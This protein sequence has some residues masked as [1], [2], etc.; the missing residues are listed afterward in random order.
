MSWKRPLLWLTIPLSL[1]AVAAN[2]QACRLRSPFTVN[3]QADA[4]ELTKCEQFNGDVN[5]SP[6]ASSNITL[7]GLLQVFGSLRATLPGHSDTADATTLISISSK[8]LSFVGGSLVI[9]SVSS[10]QSIALPKLKIVVGALEMSD[11]PSLV[12]L[13]LEGINSIGN[14]SLVSAPRLLEASIGADSTYKDRDIGLK[15]ITDTTDPAVVVRDVGLA[16]LSGL[17]DLYDASLIELAEL[18][19]LNNALLNTGRVGEVRIR[20]NGNLTLSTWGGPGVGT[21]EQVV[22]KLSITGVKHVSPCRSFD[23]HE[24]IAV[25][26]SVEYLH[27]SFTAVQRLEVRDN[28]RLKTLVPW[29][30]RNIWE[31]DLADV[32]IRDNPLLV[33]SQFPVRSANDTFTLLECPGSFNNSVDQWQWYPFHMETLA[34]D[35]A[36]NDTF[37]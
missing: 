32:L 29:N 1:F 2:A 25:N 12:D 10:L 6:S 16:S 8:T 36:I 17:V 21:T 26:N 5:I 14:F 13:H 33:L 23:V 11:L 15:Y 4:D 22:G 24:F 7:D 19:N 35:A 3:S 30:G 28:A 34:I 9:S 27:F 37:L 20:G 31:W 18:P